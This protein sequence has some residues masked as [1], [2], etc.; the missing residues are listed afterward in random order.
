MSPLGII[1]LDT[2]FAR[3]PG[4]VG[5]PG[6]WPFEVLFQRVSGASARKVVGGD[7]G[8]LLDAFIAAGQV[9]KSQGAI[10]LT[11]SCGFLASRQRELAARMPLPIATSSLMQL[12]LIERCL[13]E[14]RRAGVITYDADSLTDRHFTG[15]G[16]N[17]STP[18]V[19]LPAKGCFRE[20]IEGG[21]TYDRAALKQ[22]ILVA[23]GVLIDAHPEIGA[24]V[25]ECA[26]LPPFS[27][28]VSRAFAMPVYDIITLGCWFHAGLR[29][30]PFA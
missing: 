27:A 4:D 13:P 30:R 22:E 11:T 25:F 2:N 23:A 16:A 19:G 1:M 3:P 8:E 7:E 28:D 15:V 24:L 21:G 5:N 10:G 12:P 26:N 9:L 18:R 17:A 6:S 29:Q 14:G 20:L